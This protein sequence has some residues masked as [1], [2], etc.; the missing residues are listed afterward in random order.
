LNQ[1]TI[2]IYS[3][4]NQKFANKL[5][6]YVG[7]GSGTRDPGSGKQLYIRI[8]DPEITHHIQYLDPQHWMALTDI[9]LSGDGKPGHNI[10]IANGDFPKKERILMLSI[11]RK[12]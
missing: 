3:T 4:F 7:L 2:R 8:L 6:K 9:S 11:Q 12:L 10:N 1:N 5:S